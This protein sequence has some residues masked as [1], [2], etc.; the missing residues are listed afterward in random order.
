MYAVACRRPSGRPPIVL[1]H[2]LG[3]SHRYMMPLARELAADESVLAPDFPG[4]GRSGKPRHIL[5]VPGL[6]GAVAAWMRALDLPPAMLVGNS[7]G[8]QVAVEAA[9]AAPERVM[10][11]VLQGPTAAPE[12]RNWLM[13]YRRWRQNAPF[14][15]NE[16]DPICWEDYRRAGYVRTLWTFHLSLHH[17]LEERV[18]DIRVPVLVVRGQR[19]PICRDDWAMALTERLPDGRLAVIPKV[20]HTLCFTSPVELGGVVRTF[21]RHG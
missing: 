19:D 7:F 2:G 20:A 17:R 8:C 9:L 1:V 16:L 18:G 6:G 13:Q 12:E 14:S 11:L 15:P 5:D 4:F 10:G 21:L 3:L